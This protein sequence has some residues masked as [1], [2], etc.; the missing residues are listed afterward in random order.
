MENVIALAVLDKHSSCSETPW[1]AT[2]R[3]RL[4]INAVATGTVQGTTVPSAGTPSTTAIAFGYGM[5]Q[6]DETNK[7]LSSGHPTWSPPV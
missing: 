5:P 7:A 2:S 3:E 4:V 6:T 1:R